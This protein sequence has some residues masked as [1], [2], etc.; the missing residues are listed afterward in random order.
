MKQFFIILTIL[1][2]S[3]VYAKGQGYLFPLPG[4][5]NTY[6]A[7]VTDTGNPNEVR[8]YVTTD[9]AGTTRAVHG[10]DFSFVTPGY[11][12]GS[13]QLEGSAVYSIDITWGASVANATNF[14]VF[15]EVDDDVTNCTNLMGLHVQIA[16][17][18]NVVA[19][20]VTGSATPATADPSSPTT[21]VIAAD[22]P[23]VVNPIW[24]EA[25]SGHTDIGDYQ[26]VFR[27]NREFSIQEWQFEYQLSEQSAKPFNVEAIS[28]VDEG[29]TTV[30]SGTDLS[31]VVAVD[32]DENYVLVYVTITNQQ[33][34]SLNIDFNLVTAN[35]NTRDVGNNPDSNTS[36]NLASFEIQAMPAITGFGGL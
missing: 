21:D 2:F 1:V 12:A 13:E 11:N 35:G 18:F 30:Y 6:N 8:W 20:N 24:S 14:Y 33:G 29:G 32:G 16:A 7:T 3:I 31:T 27:V 17:D 25:T 28:M 4:G 10:T 5:T 22:C 15:I 19:Y 9:Q 26:V 36:D 34:A 23:S